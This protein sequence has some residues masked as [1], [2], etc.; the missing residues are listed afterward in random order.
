MLGFFSMLSF[1][2]LFVM[3]AFTCAFVALSYFS[4]IPFSFPLFCSLFSPAELL[5]SAPLIALIIFY[6]RTRCPTNHGP[7]SF[8]RNEGVICMKVRGA[9]RRFAFENDIYVE[10]SPHLALVM[11]IEA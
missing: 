11:N 10:G 4:C 5:P 1:F 7:S 9:R 3:L 8:Q 2:T 6:D